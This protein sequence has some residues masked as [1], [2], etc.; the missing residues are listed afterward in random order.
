MEYIT[1]K[2]ILLVLFIF[3]IVILLISYLKTTPW[4]QYEDDVT[5]NDNNHFGYRKPLEPGERRFKTG[6][7][8]IIT[9]LN[10]NEPNMC[11]GDTV[12]I[13]ENK[14]YDYLVRSYSS[15]KGSYQD[16]VNQDQLELK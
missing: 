11:I 13:V 12:L 9:K 4:T 8:C 14:R 2:N 10:F 3:V 5:F 15:L 6:S 7:K 1:P 16:I